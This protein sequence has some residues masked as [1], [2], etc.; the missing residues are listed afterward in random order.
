[1]VKFWKKEDGK[2][3][4]DVTGYTCPYPV[5]YMKNALNQISSGDT[6]EV[7]FDNPPSCETLPEAAGEEGH[8]IINM[9]K[10]GS[11]LWRL[12]VRKR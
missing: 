10:I 6:L 9:E 2:Y 5:I 1:M 7:I 11:G 4:L 3:V 12:I 8:K